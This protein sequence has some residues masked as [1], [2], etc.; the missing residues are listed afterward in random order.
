MTVVGVLLWVLAI[1]VTL[2]TAVLA[3]VAVRGHRPLLALPALVPIA[4]GI[5][6]VAADARIDPVTR[7]LPVALAFALAAVGVLAGSP[8]TTAVLDRTARSESV[9]AHGGILVRQEGA[10]NAPPREIMRGGS[11]IGYLERAA[12]VGAIAIG[13]PEVL[14]AVI[15]VKGLGRFSELDTSEARER[16]IIGTLVSLI[17]S[18]AC[19]ALIWTLGL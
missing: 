16:F 6:L 10:T 17:W 11:A 18:S 13:H 7:G 14:V 2:A 12:V 1:L 19:G 9:G 15:A 8:L 5:V 3:V 4:V